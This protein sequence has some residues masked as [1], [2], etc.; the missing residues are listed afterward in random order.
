[1]ALK[2]ATANQKKK[3][4]LSAYIIFANETRSTIKANNP[5]A[6]FGQLGKLAGMAWQALSPEEKMEYT[7][8]AESAKKE[9]TPPNMQSS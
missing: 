2:A 5:E 9:N 7:A 4:P 8:K 6:T 3:R 1:M